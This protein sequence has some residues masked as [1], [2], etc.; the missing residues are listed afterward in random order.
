MSGANTLT[1]YVDS[2]VKLNLSP[3][4]Q[5]SKAKNSLIACTILNLISLSLVITSGFLTTL[6]VAC[7]SESALLPNNI[8]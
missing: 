7:K 6:N 4:S 5:N 1:I 2:S 3:K 8:L